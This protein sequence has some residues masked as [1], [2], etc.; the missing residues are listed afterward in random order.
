M[1]RLSSKCKQLIRML[2]I[3]HN[4]RTTPKLYFSQQALDEELKKVPKQ[5][6]YYIPQ[7]LK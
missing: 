4:I 5:T 6:P 7:T 2:P 1:L 3:S